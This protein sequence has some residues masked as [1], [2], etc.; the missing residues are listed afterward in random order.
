MWGHRDHRERAEA[1]GK[2]RTATEIVIVICQVTL[3]RSPPLSGPRCL[4]SVSREA[5]LHSGSILPTL[6]TP[7]AHLPECSCLQRQPPSST[8]MHL[9]ASALSQAAFFA[10][11]LVAGSFVSHLFVLTACLVAELPGL[12]GTKIKKFQ[13]PSVHSPLLPTQS[14]ERWLL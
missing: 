5:C 14:S 4:T 13:T 3:G 12:Q 7:T 9:P 2:A 6:R 10:L 1:P 11:T 8:L